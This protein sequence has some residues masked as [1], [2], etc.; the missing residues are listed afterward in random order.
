MDFL[1]VPKRSGIWDLTKIKSE[2]PSGDQGGKGGPES[3]RSRMRERKKT[4]EEAGYLWATDSDGAREVKILA[5]SVTVVFI[6]FC[7]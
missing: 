3:K 6:Y 1:V 4:F 5:R 7:C 2:C